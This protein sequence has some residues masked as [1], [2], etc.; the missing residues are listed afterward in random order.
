[1]R[2]EPVRFVGISLLLSEISVKRADDFIMWWLSFHDFAGLK[3]FHVIAKRTRTQSKFHATL[4][5]QKHINFELETHQIYITSQ[6]TE[7]LFNNFVSEILEMLH[8][9]YIYGNQGGNWRDP[10]ILY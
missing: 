4:H 6:K 9:F 10:L 8:F 1:M 7:H 5:D 3:L 2:N